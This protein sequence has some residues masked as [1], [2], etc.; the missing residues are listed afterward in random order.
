MKSFILFLLVFLVFV[1]GFY[2]FYFVKRDWYN[3]FVSKR[4]GNS[5]II[6]GIFFLICLIFGGGLYRWLLGVFDLL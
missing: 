2:L 5:L 1:M 6:Y 4:K 3:K